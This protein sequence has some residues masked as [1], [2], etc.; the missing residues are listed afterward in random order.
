MFSILRHSP[1]HRIHS[2]STT[3]KKRR[4][5]LSRIQQTLSC[6]PRAPLSRLQR[7]YFFY[8][9]FF[10]EVIDLCSPAEHLFGR[11]RTRKD[12]LNLEEL[13]LC[14]TPRKTLINL[15]RSY[16]VLP[17]KYQE[18]HLAFHKTWRKLTAKVQ[19]LS[20]LQ[21]SVW[22]TTFV[23]LCKGSSHCVC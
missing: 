17:V 3:D 11:K 5:A 10:S 12:S 9:F 18:D 1:S 14:Q 4:A 23:I 21:L 13:T 19:L 16:S 2:K 22:E 20:R 6:T 7:D 8:L 15:H